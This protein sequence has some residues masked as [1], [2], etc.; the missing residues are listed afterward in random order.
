MLCVAEAASLGYSFD[1]SWNSSTSHSPCVHFLLT[2]GRA[3]LALG[4]VLLVLLNTYKEAH[5]GCDV[6]VAG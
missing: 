2:R 5:S 1:H 3:L 4:A 6:A